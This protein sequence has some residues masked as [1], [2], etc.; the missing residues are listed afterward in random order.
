MNNTTPQPQAPSHHLELRHLT[1]DDYQGIKQ[2]QEE[3]Y[4]D[5]GSWS[6]KKYQAQ[7]S[8]FPEGQICV[9]DKGEVIAAAF[10]LIVDYDKFGDKHTYNEITGDA[11]LTTHDPNG[12]VLYGIEVMVSPRYR[13][14]RLGRRLYDAR[15]ELCRNL[16][17]KS[18]IAGGRIPNY[19]TYADTMTPH[20][21]IAKVKS[22]DLYDPI[23]TFQLSNDFDVKQVLKS[24]LPEDTESR[25]YATLLQWHNI[26]YDAEAHQLI[27]GVRSSARVGL[28]QWQM[29]Y[30]LSAEDMLQ[31]VEY[32]IDA[33]ADYQCDIAI[34]PEFFNAPLMGLGQDGVTSIDSIWH[35]ASYSNEILTA[36]S[37]LA[38]TYNINIIAGSMPVVNEDELYNISYLCRRDGTVDQQEKL[39]PT[40]YEKRAWIMQGGSKL[41]AFDTDIG[42]IGILICYDVE[43]PELAR[44]TLR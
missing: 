33:L 34:L 31:Q 2:L 38:V 26:Y 19:G 23:L 42:K 9:E 27:G 32:F 40:P 16:N 13:D 4:P 12:D 3:T 15:K 18:I 39:H 14:L 6:L 24:Y 11:Y 37:R 28:L 8:V 22:K 10:A 29:R 43:F 36:M 41:K 5:L 20:E 35:L 7:L 17:L 21:Y 30:F 1:L 25:G 44:S